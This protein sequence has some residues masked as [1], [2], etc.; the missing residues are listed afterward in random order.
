MRKPPMSELV[1]VTDA[2]QIAP[3][4]ATCVRIA[5]RNIAVF[6]ID[7]VYYAIDNACSHRGAP[8]CEG[9]VYRHV[10]TC[11]WHG[12]TFDVTTGEAL[13]SP[14]PHGVRSYKVQVVDGELHLEIP[15]SPVTFQSE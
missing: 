3:G 15:A 5:G 8:L 10:V 9:R 11:P 14:A 12:A 2:G 13:A 7:G 4:E 6:N 1:A